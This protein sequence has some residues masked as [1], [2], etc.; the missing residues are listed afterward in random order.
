MNSFPRQQ[1]TEGVP[2]PRASRLLGAV[3]CESV[4]GDPGNVVW[5]DDTLAEPEIPGLWKEDYKL[6]QVSASCPQVREVGWRPTPADLEP[7]SQ[8]EPLPRSLRSLG[9][10]PLCRLRK[11]HSCHTF[12][13]FLLA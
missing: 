1:D 7:R 10:V 5:E 8:T 6:H 13:T 2:Y 4:Q 9:E 12:Q 11:Y 3:S